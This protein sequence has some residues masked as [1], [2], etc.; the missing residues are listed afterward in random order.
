MKTPSA[1][2]HV[3]DSSVELSLLSHRYWLKKKHLQNDLFFVEL[4][5][6]PVFNQ[7][8]QWILAVIASGRLG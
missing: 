4:D 5:V 7:L 6:K 8:S 2:P 1:I 3:A